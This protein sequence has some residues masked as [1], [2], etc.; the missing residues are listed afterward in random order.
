MGQKINPT[1]NRLPLTKA[2]RSRW[3]STRDYRDRLLEDLRIRAF[4]EER[5]GRQSALARIELKRTVGGQVH[6][7]LH[8]SKPGIIIGRAGAGIM[9]LRGKLETLLGI[10]AQKKGAA[11][12]GSRARGGKQEGNN[13]K[14]DIV[15]VRQ[16]ELSA[17]LVAENIAS[18]IERRIAYRRAVRQSMERVMQAGAKGVKMVVSG[19]LGGAEISRR[20]KFTDGSVPLSTFRADIDYAHVEARTAYGTIGI[21]VWIHRGALVEEQ[22]PQE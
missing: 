21:K 20:E 15:E 8:A 22:E 18:Q 12:T 19:R 17:L 5:Y 2:W 10:K 4:L 3:I 1:S 7:I 6:V 13:L 14:I 16:P 9:E 11:S